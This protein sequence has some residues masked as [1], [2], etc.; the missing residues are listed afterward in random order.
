MGQELQLL[1][2]EHGHYRGHAPKGLAARGSLVGK[3]GPR[4]PLPVASTPTLMECQAARFAHN[5]LSNPNPP[6]VSSQVFLSRIHRKGLM[7][8]SKS[9]CL[10]ALLRQKCQSPSGAGPLS[11]PFVYQKRPMVAKEPSKPSKLC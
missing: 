1:V 6:F 9:S 8:C 5:P 10:M 2:P 3:R 7:P 11:P 4:T